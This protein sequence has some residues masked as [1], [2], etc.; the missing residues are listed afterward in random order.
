MPGAQAGCSDLLRSRIRNVDVGHFELDEVRHSSATRRGVLAREIPAR[1]GM[2]IA[3]SPS[4][5][6]R[7][8]S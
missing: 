7:T 2:R 1:S 4:R 6:R 5:E 8:W 3:A